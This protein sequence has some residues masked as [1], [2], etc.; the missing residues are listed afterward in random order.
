VLPQVEAKNFFKEYMED[1]NTVT[2]PH[3]K[4]YDI[5]KWEMKEA[6][7]KKKKMMK[8]FKHPEKYQ[9]DDGVDRVFNDEEELRKVRKAAREK[10][11][12]EERKTELLEK[13]LS[14][15]D[16]ERGARLKIIEA[17]ARRGADS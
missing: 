15:I 2:L 12:E 6:L 14:A 10:E 16:K 5:E 1:F 13:Q 17:V 9:L 3:K 11:K 4:Y 8:A 7:K